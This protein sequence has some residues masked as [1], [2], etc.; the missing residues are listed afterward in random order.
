MAKVRGRDTRP[1]MLVRR[2]IHGMGFRYRLHARHLPGRPDLVFP[3]RQKV[4]FVHGC[5]WHRHD[6]CRRATI[7]QG[8]RE[9][10]QSKLQR[11]VIRDEMQVAALKAGGWAVLV[12]WECETKDPDKTAER[13][14]SFLN[15]GPRK[16]PH[17]R[18]V[19]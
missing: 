17:P 16:V 8:N 7:P 3:G 11:N 6:G 14:R 10:W 19:R 5:F 18:S 9:F 12:I 15:P 1:E 13:V 2:L 4:I